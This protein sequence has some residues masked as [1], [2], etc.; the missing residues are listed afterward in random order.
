MADRQESKDPRP[1][2]EETK[3]FEF[4]GTIVR[5]DQ[6]IE[7]TSARG[8]KYV[9]LHD[10]KKI[11]SKLLQWLATL[12]LTPP[13]FRVRLQAWRGVR[14]KDPESVFIGDGVNFDER[15]PETI[16]LGR[17]VWIAAGCRIISHR[18]ISYRF[19]EKAPVVLEDY[20]RVAVNAVVIGPVRIGE[21]AM[22]G[23]GAVV[24]KDVPPYTVVSGVNAKPIG[25]VPKKI[26]DYELLVKG[27]FE[28]G[29]S[30]E[31]LPPADGGKTGSS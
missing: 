13:S 17:G 26:V 30:I 19:V 12:Y 27:D 31:K 28:T 11:Y 25:P 10:R 8:L 15:V 16:S 4:F 6:T 24:T 20:V 3:C 22:I 7:H 23:P 5:L 1:Q 29:T 21:G 18:F 2:L 14:F 9:L